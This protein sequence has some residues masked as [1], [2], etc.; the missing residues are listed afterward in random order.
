[1]G[2]R[3]KGPTAEPDRTEAWVAHTPVRAKAEQESER[4][5]A[6]QQDRWPPLGCR[7]HRGG[8]A[9]WGL[10]RR[11]LPSPRALQR[12]PSPLPALLSPGSHRGQHQGHWLPPLWPGLGPFA[13]LGV[14]GH[15]P[16]VGR[17]G[18]S[19]SYGC[20]SFLPG[21]PI[22]DAGLPTDLPRGCLPSPLSSENGRL[23]SDSR[24]LGGLSGRQWRPFGGTLAGL[25]KVEAGRADC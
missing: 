18:P 10:A 19:A 2:R 11:E 21:S 5:R 8:P 9:G 7:E 1:M 12:W 15:P 22:W 17:V 13:R 14:L 23:V 25:G 3:E 6:P 16:S 4:G 20:H 24:E